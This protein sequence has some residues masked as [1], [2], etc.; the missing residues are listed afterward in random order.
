MYPIEKYKYYT[1]G[2]SKVIATSTYAGKT[3]RGVAKC[4]PGD[5]FDLETGKKIAAARCA[6]RVAEK[7]LVRARKKTDEA[8]KAVSSA[9]RYRDKMID[10]E[11]DAEVALTQA[12]DHITALFEQI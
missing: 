10:Y 7:R 12:I 6:V 4:A 2:C 11:N 3:V 9:R 5:K 8:Y 1:D